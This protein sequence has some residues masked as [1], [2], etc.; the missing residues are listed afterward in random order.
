MTYSATKFE[1]ATSNGLGGDTFT[2]NVT[3]GQ[4][5]LLLDSWWVLTVLEKSS[6]ESVS[7]KQIP[8]IFY[9]INLILSLLA[10]FIHCM[11]MAF[12]P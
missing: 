12:V 2:R 8:D 7:T 3:D 6:Q 4:T 9:R 5:F 1:A 10:P 11:Q